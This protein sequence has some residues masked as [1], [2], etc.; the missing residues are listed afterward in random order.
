M[1]PP[2]SHP[3]T[4]LSRAG[5]QAVVVREIR[6]LMRSASER[7]KRKVFIAEGLSVAREILG[8]QFQTLHALASP[9]L[10]STAEGRALAGE[11]VGMGPRARLVDDKTLGSL[12][13]VPSSQGVLLVISRPRWDLAA[14][15]STLR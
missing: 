11:L 3:L 7:R 4:L 2:G 5:R 9:K 13:D 10:T 6:K 12:S 1:N 14:V 8:G 15:L